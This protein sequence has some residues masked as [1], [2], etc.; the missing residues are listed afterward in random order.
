MLTEL[1]SRDEGNCETDHPRHS[2]ERPQML[3]RRRESAQRSKMSRASSV[4]HAQFASNTSHKLG[5]T[6]LERQRATQKEQASRLQR[7]NVGAKGRWGMRQVDAKVSQTFFSISV[8]CVGGHDWFCQVR[9][10]ST[11]MHSAVDVKHFAGNLT[12]F[13]QIE[14]S[15]GDVAGGRNLPKR[16]QCAQE[17]LRSVLEQRRIHNARRHRVYANTL[18]RVLHRKA[19]GD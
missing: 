18:L 4:F 9:L 6:V 2:I 15:L 19:A 16:R 8:R 11:E 5:D 10:P 7:L 3:P 14:N 12:R 1:R 13:S 17:V